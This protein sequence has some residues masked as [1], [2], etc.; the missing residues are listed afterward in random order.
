MGEND[1]ASDLAGAV[2]AMDSVNYRLLAAL[3]KVAGPMVYPYWVSRIINGL[4]GGRKWT[5]NI[6]C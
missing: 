2:Q 6:L 1:L 4:V 5:R 3:N